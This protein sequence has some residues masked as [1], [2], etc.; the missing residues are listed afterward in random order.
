MISHLDPKEI[1]RQIRKNWIHEASCPLCGRHDWAVQHELYEL[2]QH[3]GNNVIGGETVIPIVPV[4][5]KKCGNTVMINGIIAG[6][7]ECE[8]Q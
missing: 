3:N 4:T 8:S 6:V 5:C 2:R 7:V 1:V